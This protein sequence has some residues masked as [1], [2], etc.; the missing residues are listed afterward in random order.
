MKVTV[1]IPHLDS[2]DLLSV[3]IRALLPQLEGRGELL[4]C[5]NGSRREHRWWLESMAI[6]GVT[7]VDASS[8]RGPSVARN[9]GIARAS[10]EVCLFC[11]ADDIVC[12]DWVDAHLH[13]LVS[14][15]ASMGPCRY[16]DESR[17]EADQMLDPFPPMPMLQGSPMVLSGNFGCRTEVLRAIS[18]F[19]ESLLTVEDVEIGVRLLEQG[20]TIGV[21]K[22]ARLLRRRRGTIVGEFRRVFRYGRGLATLAELHPGLPLK[23]SPLWAFTG[24]AA[25]L[26][27][28]AVSTSHREAWMAHVARELGRL[29]GPW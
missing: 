17:P 3:Q 19:D 27:L 14:H 1:V 5:D 15:D 10:G 18:G 21:A 13:T 20:Y 12:D 11:D 8:R 28:L 24:A 2:V 4:V 9:A 25:R 23:G 29:R 16:L 26:P 7:L 6:P 22:G